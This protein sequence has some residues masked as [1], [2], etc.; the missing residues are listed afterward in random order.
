M[1]VLQTL[2]YLYAWICVFSCEQTLVHIFMISYRPPRLRFRKRCVSVYW[3]AEI[4]SVEKNK[5]SSISRRLAET[6][7]G[8]MNYFIQQY[9]MRTGASQPQTIRLTVKKPPKPKTKTTPS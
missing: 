2:L 6:E 8:R 9:W 1:V 5:N 7:K 3:L 4:E